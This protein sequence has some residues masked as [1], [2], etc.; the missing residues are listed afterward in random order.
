MTFRA[1]LP[2][3][4]RGSTSSAALCALFLAHVLAPGSAQ[5]QAQIPEDRIG[6]IVQ[7]ATGAGR[8]VYAPLARPMILPRFLGRW[9][10]R[11]GRCVGQPYTDRLQ[12]DPGLAIIAGRT[13]PV[14]TVLVETA[15]Q[16]RAAP[17]PNAED[18]GYASDLLI[19]FDQA[20][21]TGVRYIHF[22]IVGLDGRLIVEE[23]GQPRRAYVRC[24]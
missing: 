5:A 7:P 18:H 11:P 21:R 10:V 16:G 8:A 17:P 19:V 3:A 4:W 24:A 13:L 6:D 14:Q 22:K 12:M 20:G 15:Q 9:A 1:P 23:V 2:T